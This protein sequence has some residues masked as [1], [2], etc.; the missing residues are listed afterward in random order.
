M[1]GAHCRGSIIYCVQNLRARRRTEDFHD[2]G[3]NC[4]RVP[5]DILSGVIDQ[6]IR[7]KQAA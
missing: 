7:T 6:Y 2:A 3:L 1:I 4:G 5:L